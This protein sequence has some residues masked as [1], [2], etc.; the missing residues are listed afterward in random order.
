MFGGIIAKPEEPGR[1][2]DE[3]DRAE[4]DEDHSPGHE[5]QQDPHQKRRQPAAQVG[6]REEN[7]LG[8]ASLGHGK[9]AR[10]GL[11]DVGKGPRLARSEEESHNQQRREIERRGRRDREARPPDHDPGQQPPR[12]DA[13]APGAGRDLEKRIGDRECTEDESHL[14]I[15]QV[16]VAHQILGRRRDA[17]AVQIG[18][19]RQR[20]GEGEHAV[21]DMR[22]AVRSIR[23]VRVNSRMIRMSRHQ[24]HAII[25][26]ISGLRV[27][28]YYP[29][30]AALSTPARSTSEQAPIRRLDSTL[31]RP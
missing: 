30:I 11:G 10:K 17:H 28:H 12:P 29:R 8:R 16:Q 15:A 24:G 21:A 13:V 6:A 27:T 31:G 14:L 3:T 9:P 7:A 19:P 20:H 1:R 26:S 22:S 4:D 2:P 23:D 5:L 18:D 25:D